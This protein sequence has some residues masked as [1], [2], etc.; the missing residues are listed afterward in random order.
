[1]EEST[2]E[3]ANGQSMPENIPNDPAASSQET[4][5]GQT[6]PIKKITWLKGFSAVLNGIGVGLLLGILLGLSVSPV[7]S[8]VIGTISGL[9]VILLGLDEKYL[10]PVKGIR[11]GAFGLSAVA[12]VILGLYIRA[13]DPL[14]PS[15]LD[16]K[17]EY[18]KL[19]F[20]EEEAKAFLTGRVS[21]ESAEDPA[22][23][24]V[25]YSSTVD[26]GACETLQYATA[27][28]PVSELMNTFK[29]AGGTWKE[30]AEEFKADLPNSLFGVALV[31]MRDCFCSL[32]TE[33]VIKLTN[34][35]EVS[36]LNNGDSLEKIEN[37]LSNSG[38]GWAA[39]K[40]KLSANIP[41]NQ[42]KEVYLTAIKVL[43]HD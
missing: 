21:A 18:V 43:T 33:G 27:E 15:L 9:L 34:R 11:I 12:G 41:D 8:G 40:N 35:K 2:T 39:I 25:L 1:M 29:E 32:A 4:E 31:S 7:V 42:R 5:P 17:N 20:S 30:L 3:V 22:K 6:S 19:G 10:D 23:K 38:P 14:S 36:K 24:N 28:Q 37:L 26:A 13:N 16:R